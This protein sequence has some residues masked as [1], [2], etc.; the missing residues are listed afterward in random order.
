MPYSTHCWV[1]LHGMCRILIAA[2]LSELLPF[3]YSLCKK[4]FR[5]DILILLVS[6]FERLWR[7]RQLSMLV[8]SIRGQTW[9]PTFLFSLFLD[10]NTCNPSLVWSLAQFSRSAHGLGGGRASSSPSS[11]FRP[12]ILTS[13]SPRGQFPLHILSPEVV[14]CCHLHCSSS[15]WTVIDIVG[16]SWKESQGEAPCHFLP[17]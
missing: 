7:L 14:R 2:L 15:R 3:A 17:L 6:I 1:L 5:M 10:F 12:V 8:S 4:I 11:L 9:L 13:P 16:S